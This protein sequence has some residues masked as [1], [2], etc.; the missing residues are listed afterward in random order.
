LLEQI[1]K[2]TERNLDLQA[3]SLKL[4]EKAIPYNNKSKATDE[5]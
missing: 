3:K 4:A 2:T 1:E 5:I